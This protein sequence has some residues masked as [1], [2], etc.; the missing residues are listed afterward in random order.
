[1]NAGPLTASLPFG[2]T[3]Y[4]LI[5]LISEVLWE[6]LF[7]R[8]GARLLFGRKLL[9]QPRAV[10]FTCLTY[11]V[12][13]F[14]GSL[15]GPVGA[16]WADALLSV[17]MGVFL[18]ALYLRTKNIFVPIAAH[19]LMRFTTE[20]FFRYSDVPGSLNAGILFAVFYALV[21]LVIGGIL[22]IR[23]ARAEP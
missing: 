11:G 17:C 19:F 20:L 4:W 10:L 22:L 14:L 23:G 8:H 2:N 1:M 9:F 5:G 16:L 3:A 7:F 12:F 13:H 15:F 21:L 6:E 18:T